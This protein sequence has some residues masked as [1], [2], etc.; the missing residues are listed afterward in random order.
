MLFTQNFVLLDII[1]TGKINLGR[2]D[3]TQEEVKALYS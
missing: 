3:A 2:D 1:A